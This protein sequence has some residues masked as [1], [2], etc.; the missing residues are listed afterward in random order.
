MAIPCRYARQLLHVIEEEGLLCRENDSDEADGDGR[1]YTFLH[2]RIQQA[3][4]MTMSESDKT[5]LHLTI[6]RVI[7]DH[8][9]E[10]E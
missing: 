5:S 9:S 4:Y 6:G 2:D 7:R 1:Y 8:L 10:R 3:A